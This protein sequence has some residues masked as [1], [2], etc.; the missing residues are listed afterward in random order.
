MRYRLM[1]LV[2]ALALIVAGVFSITQGFKRMGMVK[3][4]DYK[5]TKA[6]VSRV[7]VEES[8]D[9]DEPDSYTVYVTVNV[10]CKEYEVNYDSGSE[11]MKVGDEITVL[12]NPENPDMALA[13]SQTNSYILLGLG[14]IGVL[15]GILL[16]IRTLQ[17]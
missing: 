15:G 16:V 2:F 14:A 10:G 7:E 4:D 1:S 8:I 13:P 11:D 12:F 9:V 3:S 5:Q 6:V 17:L